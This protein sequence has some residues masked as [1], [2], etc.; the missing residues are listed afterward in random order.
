[1]AFTL[2]DPSGAPTKSSESEMVAPPPLNVWSLESVSRVRPATV[3]L[4]IPNVAFEIATFVNDACLLMD[5]SVAVTVPLAAP[6]LVRMVA[7][8]L[9]GATDPPPVTDHDG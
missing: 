4:T 7:F 2:L 5:A 1:M 8:P 9:A 6:D 3:S